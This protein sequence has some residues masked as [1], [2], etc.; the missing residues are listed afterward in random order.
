MGNAFESPFYVTNTSSLFSVYS[1]NLDCLVK[2]TET[3]EHN[4]MQDIDFG[5]FS[6][7]PKI[8]PG[9]TTS[10]FCKFMSGSQITTG[11]V[12]ITISY[13][14]ALAWFRKEIKRRFVAR[15]NSDGKMMWTPVGLEDSGG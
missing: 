11:D 12:V 15:K 2:N 5:G 6:K 8:E 14:P 10:L 7:S 4:V 3:R 1:V 13:R 9:E